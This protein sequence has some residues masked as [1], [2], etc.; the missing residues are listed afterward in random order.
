M[1][2]FHP[3]SDTRHSGSNSSSG[4]TQH[5]TPQHDTAQRSQHVPNSTST[6]DAQAAKQSVKNRDVQLSLTL[7]A[8]RCLPAALVL[9]ILYTAAPP[10]PRQA[11]IT[12]TSSVTSHVL[13]RYIRL[14]S[15]LTTCCHTT[16]SLTAGP[17]PPLSSHSA[18]SSPPPTSHSRITAFL[19]IPSRRAP[20][21]LACTHPFP[22]PPIGIARRR[23]V[24]YPNRRTHSSTSAPRANTASSA[25]PTRSLP[26]AS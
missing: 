3:A 25:T 14:T 23:S 2:T 22:C 6:R 21:S 9:H 17:P 5:S 10:H 26:A 20:R 1:H 16:D 12:T 24:R 11:R 13:R 4:S 7:I 19:S 8:Y 15:L 18:F